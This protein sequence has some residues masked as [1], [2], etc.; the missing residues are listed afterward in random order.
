[1]NHHKK[2]SWQVFIKIIW[3]Q[4]LSK[5]ETLRCG[6]KHKY[7]PV[8]RDFKILRRICPAGWTFGL[9]AIIFSFDNGKT[10]Q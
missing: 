2:L 4:K 10:R 6:H 3:K 9:I 8:G 1:L 5:F 7:K